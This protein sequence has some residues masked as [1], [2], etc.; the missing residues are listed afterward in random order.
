MVAKLFFGRVE[1]RPSRKG[2]FVEDI[3]E[4]P[5]LLKKLEN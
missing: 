5:K 1:K 2:E 4:I 3:E